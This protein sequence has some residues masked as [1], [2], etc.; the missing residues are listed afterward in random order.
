MKNWKEKCN[1]RI[2]GDKFAKWEVFW[3]MQQ[4]LYLSIEYEETEEH[5]IERARSAMN[6]IFEEYDVPAIKNYFEKHYGKIYG[7]FL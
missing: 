7:E 4:V 3:E 6:K 5:F 2:P 1:T